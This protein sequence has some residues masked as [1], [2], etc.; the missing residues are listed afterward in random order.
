MVCRCTKCKI[1]DRDIIFKKFQT[2]GK[3]TKMVKA[4]YLWHNGVRI[5]MYIS[6][7]DFI[8]QVQHVALEMY[9]NIR[10]ALF[11][12]YTFQLLNDKWLFALDRYQCC[13]F[14]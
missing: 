5:T 10:Y 4:S 6:N 11:N 2:H 13:I 12:L 7:R 14:L 1:L 9:S 3:I 8:G